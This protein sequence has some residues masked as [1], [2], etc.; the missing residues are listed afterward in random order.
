[1]TS[2][3]DVSSAY[4]RAK[5]ALEAAM[6]ASIDALYDENDRGGE[7]RNVLAIIGERLGVD[8]AVNPRE[9]AVWGRANMLRVDEAVQELLEGNA[10]R[11]AQR[12]NRYAWGS[13][14]L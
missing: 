13:G 10:R 4:Y 14:S 9:G 12:G 6:E 8:L 1:M 2:M 7:A 5:L 3:T 11:E